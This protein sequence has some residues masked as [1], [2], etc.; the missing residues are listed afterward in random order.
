MSAYFRVINININIPRRKY[1]ADMPAQ[2]GRHI[3]RSH[4]FAIKIDFEGEI[5]RQQNGKY[6]YEI[7]YGMRQ[8]NRRRRCRSSAFHIL[9][10]RQRLYAQ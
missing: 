3:N 5:K 10:N 8:W 6:Y 4:H 7:A 9:R 2:I 1:V